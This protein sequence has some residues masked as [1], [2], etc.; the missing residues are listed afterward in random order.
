MIFSCFIQNINYIFKDQSEITFSDLPSER[1][2]YT[3]KQIDSIAYNSAYN[4][5]NRI[6]S[7]YYKANIKLLEN[8]ISFCKKNNFKPVL[9]TTPFTKYYSSHFSELYK[10]KYNT[11]LKED[12]GNQIH[13]I[14]SKY[15][16]P[17]L[18]YSEDA[19]FNN[20]IS[21]FRDSSHLNLKGRK[22]FTKIVLGD[23][24]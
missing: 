4:H 5:L 3:L 9:I 17:Y 10:E 11:D 15:S 6:D 16:I 2:D 12:F 14:T 1:N 22:L 20:D 23:L 7:N 18:N 21:L 24:K 19:R 13:G 8:I